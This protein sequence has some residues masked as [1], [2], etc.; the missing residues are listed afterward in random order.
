[1]DLFESVNKLLQDKHT[2]TEAKTV[3]RVTFDNGM[4]KDIEF[5]GSFEAGKKAYLGKNVK[6]MSKDKTP[7]MLKAVK[8]E[9]I[10]ESKENKEFGISDLALKELQRFGSDLWV[11]MFS[12]PEGK[13]FR[14]D[15]QNAMNE[16]VSKKYVDRKET[17]S[18]THEK[19][20]IYK[21]TK[22][23]IK[24]LKDNEKNLPKRL[25]NLRE[26]KNVKFINE[27]EKLV[28]KKDIEFKGSFEDGKKAYL[29]KNVKAMSKDKTPVML[30]AVKVEPI[31]E[32][33]AENEIDIANDFPVILKTIEIMLKNPPTYF[34]TK[35]PIEYTFPKSERYNMKVVKAFCKYF[36]DKGYKVEVGTDKPLALYFNRD[37][38]SKINKSLKESKDESKRISISY[39]VWDEDSIEAGE[40]DDKGWKDEEGEEF[41]SVEDAIKFLKK[42]SANNPSNGAYHSGTYYKDDG[43]ENVKTGETKYLTYHLNGNWTED[44]KKAIY[45][46]ITKKGV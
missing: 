16:L 44:E 35:S 45:K 17:G 30:K 40:T 15:V 42:K 9:S 36:Q 14:K 20:Y 10:N 8:V 33:T 29:G 43:T 24:F 6:A 18:D 3:L 23:G 11:D 19:K 5:K 12:G 32:G 21:I 26:S 46:A 1:M 34:G 25:P 31:N 2:L 39:E 28:S 27:A 37:V 22:K 38:V 13:Q 41:D 7:V 4:K